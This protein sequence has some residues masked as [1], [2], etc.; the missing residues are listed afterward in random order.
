MDVHNIDIKISEELVPY[1]YAIKDGNSITDKANLSLIL[2]LFV[3]KAVTLEKAAELAQK[4]V[5]DFIDLLKSCQI[6]WGEYTEEEMQ[7][8]ET[9]MN[10]IFG[11][12][13]DET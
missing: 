7:M 11:G 6:P 12:L 10:K 8:D 5:W 9:A 1:L 4:P 13:Y 3:S 2:G